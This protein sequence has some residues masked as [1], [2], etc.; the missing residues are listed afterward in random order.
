MFSH[1]LRFLWV[2]ILLC[3]AFYPAAAQ[4][5]DRAILSPPITDDF[6]NIRA[7]LEAFDSNGAFIHGI[8][9]EDI[10]IVED[11]VSIGATELQEEEVG[12]QFIVA[13]NQGSSFAIRDSNGISRFDTLRNALSTWADNHSGSLDDLSFLSNGGLE[14]LHLNS[15]EEWLR[16]FVDFEADFRVATPSLDV[17]IRAIEIAS[18]P[19]NRPARGCSI[20]FLTP[21]PELPSSGTL[22]SII[23]MAARENIRIHVWMVSST[24]FFNSQGA[25]QLADLAAQTGGKFFAFSGTEV[26]PEVDSYLEPLR[27]VYSLIYESGIR[28]SDPHQVFARVNLKGTQIDSESHDFDLQVLPPNPILISPPIEIIREN[29]A[30]LSDTLSDID[31]YTPT[32]QKLEIL[33]EFPDGRPRPLVRS[34]LYGN[35]EVIDEKTSPPFNILTWDLTPY[36]T[37][38]QQIL[39]VEVIDSL[40]LRNSTIEQSVQITVKQSPQR[41]ISTLIDNAPIIAG[42]AAALAGGVLLLVLVVK[43]HI[44]PRAFGNQ[45]KRRKRKNKIKPVT[46]SASIDSHLQKTKQSKRLFSISSKGITLLSRRSR[47]DKKHPSPKVVA[48]LEYLETNGTGKNPGPIPVK[49]GETTFG[50]DST[51]ASITLD[52]NSLSNLHTRLVVSSDGTCLLFDEDSIAGTWLNFIPV[53]SG[54]EI[55]HHGDIIHIG[56]I[57]LCYKI[58]NKDLIPKPVVLPVE[59]PK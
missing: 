37:S 4:S 41:I 13:L 12:T 51:K 31:E 59:S 38:S 20:L 40:G 22:Q 39:Q 55:V 47:S 30:S 23:A 53:S 52:D 32:S 58:T 8:L 48:Y 11:N 35:G 57:G 29:D 9:P 56:R 45:R 43:G 10:T 50:K 6:P 24:E 19:Q 54:G 28:N 7:Y 46:G 25:E 5:A 34:T 16:V 21:P 36:E 1:R 49:V 44:H 14:S 33:V 27:Y 18:E 42:A 17:L 3:F 2:V 15:G 26:V